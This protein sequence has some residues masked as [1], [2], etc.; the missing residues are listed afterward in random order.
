MP[1]ADR[2]SG[3]AARPPAPEIEARRV[4]PVLTTLFGA[5]GTVAAVAPPCAARRTR[6][7]VTCT[8]M[9][10]RCAMP[11]AKCAANK[12]AEM[13]A[14]RSDL[15]TPWPSGWPVSRERLLARGGPSA[16]GGAQLEVSTYLDRSG[17]LIADGDR[18]QRWDTT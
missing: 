14:V 1:A 3:R 5:V 13:S 7:A 18:L 8:L 16:N 12:R 15:C 9:W 4:S 10:H 2:P 6:G 17:E 11:W